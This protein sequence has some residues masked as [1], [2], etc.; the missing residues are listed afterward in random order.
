MTL[1]C[2]SIVE[3][4]EADVDLVLGYNWKIDGHKRYAVHKAFSKGRAYET[5][6]M[7]RLIMQP[8]LGMVV[9]HI[10]G[11][12]LNN[13]RDNLRVCTPK[14]NILNRRNASSEGVYLD[15]CRWRAQI[16]FDGKRYT[17]GS[18][19][20]RKEAQ[21]ARN[22]AARRLRGEFAPECDEDKTYEPCMFSPS[23]RKLLF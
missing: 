8:R 10:D 22:W 15:G 21:K 6:L 18:F 3:L 17:V 12:G 5:I 20:N 16:G 14:E 13:R 19:K 4:D 23:I 11:N 1:N 2:G 9:D 7:H